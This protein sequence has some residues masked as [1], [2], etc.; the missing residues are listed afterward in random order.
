[1]EFTFA[2]VAFQASFSV[3]VAL[4]PD[5]VSGY[6]VPNAGIRLLNSLPEY[7]YRLKK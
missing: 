3:A 2:D 1:M 4:I 7:S 5:L 6:P